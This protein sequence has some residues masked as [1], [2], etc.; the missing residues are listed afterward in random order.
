MKKRDICLVRLAQFAVLTIIFIVTILNY[1]CGVATGLAVSQITHKIG[2]EIDESKPIVKTSYQTD[3]KTLT[4]LVVAEVK[5]TI[6][7]SE[8]VLKG[9]VVQNDPLLKKM[10]VRTLKG[11]AIAIN[12]KAQ[13][14]IDGLEITLLE[15]YSHVT[16]EG[17]LGWT[18]SDQ[19]SR[20]PFYEIIDNIRQKARENRIKIVSD[21][22]QTGLM[23]Y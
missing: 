3:V 6:D 20:G 17:V 19:S 22:V 12:I 23:L 13:E 5:A 10:Q 14:P 9:V 16:E 8:V 1:N 15:I 7:S 21:T 2:K 18:R 11:S 4:K